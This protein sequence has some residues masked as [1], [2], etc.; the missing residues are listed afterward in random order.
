[1]SATMPATPKHDSRTKAAGFPRFTGG[2]AKLGFEHLD[3]GFLR[4]IHGPEGFHALFA[5]LLFLEEFAFAR[6]VAAIAL[7]G[8]VLAQS[9]HG[10]AR[11]N[12]AANSGLNRDGVLLAGN[13][14]FELG[15]ERASPA[16]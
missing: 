9:T 4:N 16:L 11:D 5:F 3:E 12:F 6:D 10:F 7:G 14:L 13:Y 8:H 15:R 1:M 2:L